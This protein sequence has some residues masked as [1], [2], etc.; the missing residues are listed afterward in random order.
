MAEAVII[1]VVWCG[2][3]KQQM[4]GICGQALHQLVTSR[5]LDFIAAA[6]RTLCIGTAL[7][8]FVNDNQIPAL[9][10]EAFADILLLGIVQRRDYLCGTLPRVYKLLLVNGGEN[11]LELFA[12]TP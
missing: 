11:D 4:V 9:L 2:G 3:Q 5:F 8:S 6:G 10:P 7:V 12:E 1:T